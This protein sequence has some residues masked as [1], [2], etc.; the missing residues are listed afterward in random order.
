[1]TEFNLQWSK[2]LLGDLNNE[3]YAQFYAILS[4]NKIT[5]VGKAY[6]TNLAEE[7]STTLQALNLDLSPSTEVYLGRLREYGTQ[8]I[9]ST[10]MAS[11][12]HLLVFA[13]KPIMNTQ[14]K[15][16]YLGMSDLLLLNSGFD[17]LP[18]KIKAENHRVFL[19]RIP[20]EKKIHFQP[21]IAG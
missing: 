16:S 14:G 3:K 13:L 15:I 9:P 19:G 20:T 8:H 4:G 6:H 18:G 17:L 1:M 2:A 21:A 10:V 11:M 5:F 12:H 7:M